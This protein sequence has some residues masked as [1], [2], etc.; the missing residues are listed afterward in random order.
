MTFIRVFRRHAIPALLAVT[1]LLTEQGALA[2]TGVV[3]DSSTRNP[4]AGAIITTSAGVTRTD[5]HGRFETA[6]SAES[7]AARAPGYLRTEAKVSGETPVMLTLTPFRP[8]AVYLSVFGVTSATL[9]NKA[10]SLA[11]STVINALVIDVKGDRGLTP[12]RSAAREAIGAAARVTTRAA[13]EQDFPALLAR[14]HTQHLYLIARIVVLKDDPLAD[15]HPEWSVHTAEGTPWRDRENLQWMDPF[16]HDVWQHNLDVAEEAARMGFDEVQFD[17]VRFPDK[18]G[19]RFA[20]P[21]TRANRTAAIVGFL[22]AARTRLAPYNVFVSADI[23]GYVCWNLDDTAIGQQ[24]ELLGEPLDYISPI[25]YPSG[26]TWGLPGL[27]NPITDPGQIVRRSLAEAVHR[28][29]LPGVRFRPWLQAFRD[30]AFDHRLFDA[31]AISAQIT[32]ADAAGTNG[33]M[34][35]NPRNHYDAADLPLR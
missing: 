21:N 28:T 9:R 23:F 7:V 13:Q 24:I 10:V 30:Y 31:A 16:S 4:L 8:K 22:Q 6:H 12:Y 11:D 3:L 26:F 19:L 32:A 20:L 27:T 18:S 34:L 15:A 33:W 5:E 14:L 1:A 2:V 35:W 25:L 17:Y 29:H